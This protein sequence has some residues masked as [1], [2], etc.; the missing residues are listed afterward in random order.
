MAFFVA[1][2]FLSAVA[3]ATPIQA[4]V[5]DAQN[6]V[7]VCISAL[8]T[9]VFAFAI[10]RTALRK[11][12]H[13]PDLA[14]QHLRQ[15]VRIE[16]RLPVFWFIGGL[17]CLFLFE[18]RSIVR[19]NWG[20]D[21]SLLIDEILLL[22]P[23]LC[24]WLL[25]RSVQYDIENWENLYLPKCQHG[26]CCPR[27]SCNRVLDGLSMNPVGRYRFATN[28]AR[29][30]L[31]IVI[32]PLLFV[33]SFWDLSQQLAPGIENRP[34]GWV[35]MLVPLSALFIAYPLL[36]RH[37]WPTKSLADPELRKRLDALAQQVGLSVRDILIWES[38]NKTPNA[39]MT[40]L[41]PSLRYVLL[42][43]S[44][45]N[46][47]S[48]R[49]IQ[50]TFAHELGHIRF[51]HNAMRMLAMLL[52]V[53]TLGLA[54]R[55]ISQVFDWIGLDLNTLIA[56]VPAALPMFV[57][58]GLTSAYLV[59]V[60]GWFCRQLEHQAD[61]FACRALAESIIVQNPSDNHHEAA[62]KE[63]LALL[64]RLGEGT[65]RDRR[66]WLHPSWNERRRFVQCAMP[67]P[68][69]SEHDAIALRFDR[70]LRRWAYAITI[71]TSI[72]CIGCV[73]RALCS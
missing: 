9:P 58:L 5:V 52:P 25:I 26:N 57:G 27:E 33:S 41:L 12:Q 28:Q 51:H 60:F 22:T 21:K 13:E 32:A 31:G 8:A 45:I 38:P 24:P 7:G 67:A 18:W 29:F 69:G 66:T 37:L 17:C 61:Q 30:L 36:L 42:T 14:R 54:A 4:D 3:I 65:N 1:F 47:F 15:Y 43:Q 44:L 35:T 39:A 23:I 63:Y 55:G 53:V 34:M 2:A 46:R 70:R 11:L 73:Y 64:D 20:F 40:G 50:A 48:H 49:E 19:F 72:G 6:I 71:A 59:I 16:R 56:V 10:G 62:V 68:R